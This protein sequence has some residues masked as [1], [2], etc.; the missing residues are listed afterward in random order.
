MIAAPVKDLIRHKNVVFTA[1][2]GRERSVYQ[3]P[4]TPETDAEWDDL[5]SCEF[6]SHESVHLVSSDESIDVQSVSAASP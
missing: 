1:G 5:Y 3:G 4:P 2:F 6:S